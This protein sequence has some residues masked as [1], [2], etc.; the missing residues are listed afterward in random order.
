MIAALEDLLRK[1]I[2][3]D[4]Q[5]IGRT[6]LVRAV[7]NRQA[8]TGINNV[9]DYMQVVGSSQDELQHL[10]EGIV[11]PETWFFRHPAAYVELVERA[12]TWSH[13]SRSVFRVL[14]VPCS[15]GEEPYSIA[16]A[17]F[18]SGLTAERF[19]IDAV[20]ISKRSL[21]AA[22]RGVF[23]ANSL[24]ADSEKAMAHME[25]VGSGYRVSDA[26]RRQV[27]FIHG[28]LLADDFLQRVEAYDVVFCRNLLIYFDPDSQRRALQALERVL[29]PGGVLF[30]G[31]ADGFAALTFG[32]ESTG[33]S[34]A[35]G[36]RRSQERRRSLTTP[37]K[38][39]PVRSA[40]RDARLVRPTVALRTAEKP[41][42]T[43][44]VAHVRQSAPSLEDVR[45]LADAGRIGEAAE[46]C[47]RHIAAA[48]AS[49]DAF[50]LLAVV[51]DA[52]ND[53]AVAVECY[54]K[55]LYLNPRHAEALAQLALIT[56]QRGEGERAGL[57]AARARRAAHDVDKAMTS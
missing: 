12:A 32:L 20:D 48:G 40:L 41:P 35:F 39:A 17:L 54:R 29:A 45:V 55:A 14:S 1:R 44:P 13:E 30:V 25:R 28:N 7:E 37:A 23:G 22:T 57:L 16:M 50:Y 3:L 51:T 19:V 47:R 4:V 53:R 56:A 52:L 2:G 10:I 9:D 38:A 43:T 21:A 15:T 42:A 6:T 26:I 18:G 34:S 36:F 11:V 46:A 49:A 33:R 27:R 8:A 5:S 24:R 31:P